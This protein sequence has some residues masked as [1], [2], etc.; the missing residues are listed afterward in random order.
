[1]K[2]LK[3][4]QIGRVVCT[5]LQQ[6]AITTPINVVYSW[7]ITNKTATQIKV[8]MNGRKRFIAALMMKVYGF[9]Y[10]GKLYITL[11]SVKQVFGL[12][13]EKNGILHEENSDIPFEELG[14]VL[15]AI[16]ETEGRSQQEHYQRLQEFL[17]GR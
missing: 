14:K 2:R 8:S 16:I 5:I 9:N 6:L 10:C 11:N 17:H 3:K 4:R 13:T 1:M 15:D 7:G 12:Y